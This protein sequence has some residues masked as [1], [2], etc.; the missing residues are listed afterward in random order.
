MNRRETLV[1]LGLAPA[2]TGVGVETF[3][4][5]ESGMQTGRAYSNTQAAN[6]LRRLA[7]AIEA[8]EVSVFSLTVAGNMVPHDII[9][10][11]L[12]MSFSYDGPSNLAKA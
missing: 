7:A 6:A 10:H 3:I 9:K 5:P 4:K 1:M 2:A 8:E 12:E 11:R